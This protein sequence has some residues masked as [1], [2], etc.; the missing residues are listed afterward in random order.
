MHYEIQRT[1]SLKSRES[2]V[3]DLIQNVVRAASNVIDRMNRRSW[4]DLDR[5]EAGRAAT[6]LMVGL[7][8]NAFLLADSVTSETILVKPTDNIRKLGSKIYTTVQFLT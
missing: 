3:T 1:A 2:M 5:D 4:G 7:E 8:E 6:D